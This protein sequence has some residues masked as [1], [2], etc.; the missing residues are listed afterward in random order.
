M[1]FQ[2]DGEHQAQW[3]KADPDSGTGAYYSESQE[4]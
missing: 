4:Q 3:V 2:I 1:N